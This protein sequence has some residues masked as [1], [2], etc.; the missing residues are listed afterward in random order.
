M[1]LVLATLIGARGTCACDLAVP[2][3]CTASHL[4][5]ILH[6]KCRPSPT[7]AARLDAA[8]DGGG[9]FTAALAR[10]PVASRA[11]AA[12]DRA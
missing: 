8:L 12:R 2:V 6:R 5:N 7:L 4:P 1:A 10:T 11:R 9:Q 3:D